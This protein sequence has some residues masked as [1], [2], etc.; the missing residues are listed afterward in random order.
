[1][2]CRRFVGL[3]RIVV[4]MLV[5]ACALPAA[6]NGA[7]DSSAVSLEKSL[8]MMRKDTEARSAFRVVIEGRLGQDLH[9]LVIYG[10]GIGIWNGKRQFVLES[11]K[12][13]EAIDLLLEA[14]FAGMPERFAFKEEKDERPMPVGLVRVVTVTTGSTSKMVLQD[15]RGPLSKTFESLVENLVALCEE[16]AAEGISASSLEEGLKK[17]AKGQLAPETLL[18]NVNA[19]Q[20]RSLK[21]QEGQGWLLDLQHGILSLRSNVLDEGVRGIAE[22]ALSL[23]EVEK[24]A[25]SLL[26][27]GASELPP[28]I[29]TS[30]HTQL[31]IRVLDQKVRTMAREY[32]TEPDETAKTA[33]KSFLK[34]R[35]TLHDLFM[36]ELQKNGGE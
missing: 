30:G 2:Q 19:P 34:V 31:T 16:P 15:D 7:V 26:E 17:I 28:Q 8:E 32:A 10:R 33:E 22:R 23:R 24:L 18:I 9:R 21:T 3:A 11:K 25:G 27:A 20:L 14:K 6:A 1:M 29:N 35:S 5:V 36:S 13:R 12:V 4:S